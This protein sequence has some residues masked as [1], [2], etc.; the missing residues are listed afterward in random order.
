VF[1]SYSIAEMAKIRINKYIASSGMVSRR[2]ADDLVKR[3]RVYINS[4]VADIGDTVQT[5]TDEVILNGKRLVPREKHYLVMYKPKFVVTTMHDPEGRPCVR[6]FISSQYK[7]VFPVG[8]L[9]FDAQGLLILTNDGEFAH[10]LHHPSYRVQKTYIVVLRP[11]VDKDQIKQIASGIYMDG[12]MARPYRVG[13]TGNASG[14]TRIRM[15]LQQGLKNQIKRMAI[16]VGLRVVS[17]KRISVGPVYLGNM[18]PGEIRTLRKEE[19]NTIYN[20]LKRH[21]ET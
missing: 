5:E 20:L 13:I 18:R 1:F 6:D 9:D 11:K 17:I 19:I 3:G 21:K 12:V 16:A 14:G 15:I 10:A 7:G 8:R 2:K 4:R